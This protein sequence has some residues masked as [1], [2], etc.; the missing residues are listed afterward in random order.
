MLVESFEF[1]FVVPAYRNEYLPSSRLPS[2]L[3]AFLD[4]AVLSRP[5]SRAAA[6]ADAYF[7]PVW[8]Q[9]VAL[10]RYDAAIVFVLMVK[11]CA[12]ATL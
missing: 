11:I 4:T 12:V 2:S 9:M 7:L 1:E 10:L 6:A 8:L 5:R 3:R